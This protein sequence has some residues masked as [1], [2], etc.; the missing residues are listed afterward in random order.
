M[1]DPIVEYFV[2]WATNVRHVAANVKF[3]TLITNFYNQAATN[4]SCGHV[5]ISGVCL[6]DPL[7]SPPLKSSK[8]LCYNTA[9]LIKHQI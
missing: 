1:V 3:L 6:L 4:W 5:F 8:N 7:Q 2:W 9:A